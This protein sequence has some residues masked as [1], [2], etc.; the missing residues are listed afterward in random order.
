MTIIDCHAHT[1][2][3]G[4]TRDAAPDEGWRPRVYR[5]DGKQVIDYVGKSIRSAIYEIVDAK[6]MLAQYTTFG[7]DRV[8]LAPWVSI[9]RYN[10][11]PDEGL[12]VSRIHNEGLAGLAQQYPDRIRALGSVP[13]QNPALAIREL[14]SLMQMP[15]IRGIEVAASVQ[16]V[17]L[18]DDRFRDFWAAVEEHDAFVFIHP[19]TR[20]F[21]IDA[22]NDYYLWNTVGNPMETTIA[23]A[24]MVMAGIMEAHPK[25]KI[26]LAHGGGAIT[27]LRGRLTHSHTFQPQAKAR[28]TEA[29]ADSI[30]RFY[31]DTVTHDPDVLRDLVSA[32]G[33]EHVLFGT[34]YPFDMGS[35]DHASAIGDLGLSDEDQQ[36]ILGGN[37]MRLLEWS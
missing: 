13:L 23:A 2:V 5:E 27:A 9:L 11:D 8:L 6:A 15:G 36:L 10:V 32:V 17:Y 34:D 33:V 16:G 37:A 22:L 28:L 24:H 18:G 35:Y 25:L 26:M 12:R 19:T 20:G 4:I 30:R 21:D 14:E 3:P 7:I 31:Y 29:S 1:I